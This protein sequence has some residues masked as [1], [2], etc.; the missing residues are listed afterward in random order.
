MPVW[1]CHND[2]FSFMPIELTISPITH[3]GAAQIGSKQDIFYP[4]GIFYSTF[5][6]L[7][8]HFILIDFLFFSIVTTQMEI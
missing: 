1:I 5:L 3:K 2:R 4:I 6:F 8:S 7:I